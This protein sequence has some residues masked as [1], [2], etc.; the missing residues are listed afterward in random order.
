MDDRR[1]DR[2]LGQ[3][4]TIFPPG[5]ASLPQNTTA[6]ETDETAWLVAGTHIL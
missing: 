1:K 4:Q 5:E 6:A 2:I 3:F